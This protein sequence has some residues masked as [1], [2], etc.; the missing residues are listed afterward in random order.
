PDFA[1]AAN[2]LAWLLVETGGNIDRALTLAQMAKEKMPDDPAVAD[3]LGWI[4][5]HKKAYAS[6][7]AQL[8]DAVAKMPENPSIRYHLAV[9]LAEKGD[10][11]RAR[12]ELEKILANSTSFP[13][14]EK[15]R[16]LLN[17]VKSQKDS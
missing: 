17:K 15:A 3:T 1:P 10:A 12:T 2:N 16:D 4:F 9:A 7:V 8:E 11:E 5:V 14:K 6:A 13:E